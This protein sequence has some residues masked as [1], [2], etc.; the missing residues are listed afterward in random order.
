LKSFEKYSEKEFLGIRQNNQFKYFTYREIFQRICHFSNSFK[1][2]IPKRSFVG[3]LSDTCLEWFISDLS[4]QMIG[5]IVV[6]IHLNCDKEQLISIIRTTNC[7][8]II[9]DSPRKKI[10]E[11]CKKETSEIL[12]FIIEIGGDSKNSFSSL[13]ESSNSD[14][15]ELEKIEPQ[16]IVTLVF[17]SGSSGIPKGVIH[18]EFMWKET[19][20]KN[21]SSD[22]ENIYVTFSPLS[23]LTARMKY[24]R[25]LI[26]GGKLG[27][28]NPESLFEDTRLIEPT[29]FVAPP[30][31]FNFIYQIYHDELNEGG[32][33]IKLK[34][35]YS[36][37][38]G[39]KIRRIVAGGSKMSPTVKEFIESLFSL[40]V[41]DTY[42]TSETMGIMQSNKPIEGVKIKLE[43]VPE[44]GYF[45]NDKPNPRGEILMKSQMISPGY[46]GIP[47]K[48]NVDQDGYYHTGDVAEQLKDGSFII[49]DRKQ[50][51]FKMQNSEWV[52]PERI[53]NLI[54]SLNGIKQVFIFP[55]EEKTCL[56]AILVTNL[57]FSDDI[58]LKEVKDLLKDSSFP[59]Y[60]IPDLLY[61]T[62]I[63]FTI[64]NELLTPSLKICRP[65]L[66]KHFR[67]EIEQLNQKINEINKNIRSSLI[68]SIS[69]LFESDF[70][71]S[72]SFQEI[73]GDSLSAVK[74]I[75]VIE[76]K[77]NVKVS[78]TEIY[79]K[80]FLESL[81][82]R[83]QGKVEKK[84]ETEIEL[85]KEIQSLNK[86]P[87]ENK[88]VLLTGSTGFLGEFMLKDLLAEGFHVYCLI[89]NHSKG[90]EF[91][92][93]YSKESKVFFVFGDLGM[94]KM[95]I[96][97][98]IYEELSKKIS[99]IYHSGALVNHLFPYSML[100][101]VNVYGTIE[102]LK[103]AVHNEMKYFYHISSTSVFSGTNEEISEDFDISKLK[104]KAKGGYSKSKFVS[105]TLLQEARTR[106][107][108]VTIY[109]P[110]M[111]SPCSKTGIS[112]LDDWI[113]GFLT[114]FINYKS[115]PKQNG[116]LEMCPV[117]FISNFIVKS[118]KVNPQKNFHLVHPKVGMD[119]KEIINAINESGYSVSCNENYKDWYDKMKII[120]E[121]RN[122]IFKLLPTFTNGIPLC[123]NF[124]QKIQMNSTKEM[125]EKL[126]LE[127]PSF[128][129]NYISNILKY[130]S[131]ENKINSK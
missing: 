86:I 101:K 124:E 26:V 115:C 84:E 15:L 46:Y 45:I 38:L 8:A 53:E 107:I 80:N 59:N 82:K 63:E 37:I 9:C 75:N 61:Q 36:A 122:L 119:F 65:K 112:N 98:E 16:D 83:I 17:T 99:K 95:G 76:N 71:P 78:S 81:M 54:L 100:K 29:S 102:L 96:K 85:P 35:K 3:I 25:A 21:K 73:G 7:S 40:P 24:I 79:E 62:Q 22:L 39:T 90:Q 128:S 118:S 91:I 64:E 4:C 68:D 88:N 48:L 109:R 18:T 27:I 129:K 93:K 1:N 51:F 42:G 77:F 67:T 120:E 33:E 11:E 117:D 127:C 106:K 114:T 6:P 5:F 94:V 30:R 69:N 32:N 74:L 97:E 87:L 66:L 56:F 111:I 50:N 13:E 125:M 43:S 121:E 89:R 44:L 123:E 57:K 47:E 34:E 49:I 116:V 23:H 58:L 20:K 10:L 92:K 126:E 55:N 113:I 130:L 110:G 60:E 2:M 105:E 131:K 70:D 19:L 104:G 41:F 52:T 103:F 72:K 14:S 108:P 12:K 31:I 28:A